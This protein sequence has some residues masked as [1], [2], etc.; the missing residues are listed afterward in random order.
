MEYST[1]PKSNTLS[2]VIMKSHL[3]SHDIIPYAFVYIVKSQLSLLSK[4]LRMS[5]W[6]VVSD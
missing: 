5:R 1:A 2:F 4:Y 3:R 6:S